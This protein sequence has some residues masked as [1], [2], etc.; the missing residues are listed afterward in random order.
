MP[1][2]LR[3][4]AG[5]PAGKPPQPLPARFREVWDAH[6]VLLPCYADPARPGRWER[7][8]AALTGPMVGSLSPP[9]A[10]AY[11]RVPASRV[12][13]TLPGRSSPTTSRTTGTMPGIFARCGS[14]STRWGCSPPPLFSW[15]S[16]LATFRADSWLRGVLCLIRQQEPEVQEIFFSATLPRMRDLILRLPE[17]LP[18]PIPLLKKG[19]DF[20]V[21]LTQEQVSLSALVCALFAILLNWAPDCGVAG[22]RL[23]LLV[24]ASQRIRGCLSLDQF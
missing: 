1:F 12:P 20:A 22:L 14:F 13:T 15:N 4:D 18:A 19:V 8:V 7:I 16:C 24:P 3:S 9:I 5:E 21:T 10:G 23:F 2:R 11:G 17:L 6:H